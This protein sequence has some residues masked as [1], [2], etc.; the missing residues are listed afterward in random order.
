VLTW[1]PHLGSTS[2]ATASASDHAASVPRVPWLSQEP[3]RCGPSSNP[4]GVNSGLSRLASLISAGIGD[5]NHLAEGNCK[6]DVR[7]ESDLSQ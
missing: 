1:L 2:R 7:K 5:A 4:G 3:V 6:A